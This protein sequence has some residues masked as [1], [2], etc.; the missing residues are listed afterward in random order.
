[1]GVDTIDFRNNLTVNTAR[2]PSASIWA[3]CPEPELTEDPG[4]GMN[5]FD[6][7][8]MT[9][10]GPSATGGVIAQSFGQWDAYTYQGGTITDGALEG[11]VIV[12]G[13]DGDNEGVALSSGT[14]SFRLVTTSTLTLNQ[15]LWFECRIAL[16][17]IATG[18]ND[19][20]IGLADSFLSSGLPQAAWP[21]QTTNDTLFAAM[22]AIGFQRKGSVGTDISF[23][24]QL[25]GATAVYPTNLTTLC[26]TVSPAQTLAAATFVKLGFIFDPK[27]PSR[28]VSSASTGQTAGAI[29]RPLVRIFVN[30][31]EM[32]AFL[33]SDNLGGAAFPTGFMAPA[34]GIMNQTGT[35]PGTASIDWIRTAQLANS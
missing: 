14:G 30:G 2:G 11:G 32:P 4:V 9:G 25:S 7:F 1:M 16:S 15:K 3:D 26:A 6:D 18:K 12:I 22:N 21:I 24:Y 27:A 19:F 20:F 17:T 10:Q 29:K 13:S 31:L 5:F 34:I 35:T 8:L 23:V 33:T 28:Q